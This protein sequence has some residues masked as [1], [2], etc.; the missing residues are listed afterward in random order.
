M[1]TLSSEPSKPTGSSDCDHPEFAAIVDVN[2]FEDSKGFMAEIRI[3]CSR[4][5]LPFRFLGLPLGLHMAGAAMAV[6][7]LEARIAIA[8][9]DRSFHPLSDVISFGVKTS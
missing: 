6:D 5:N 4:C 9:S 7:G 3:R 8:P 1:S 2:R